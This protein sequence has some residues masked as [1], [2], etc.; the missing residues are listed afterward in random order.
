M[1]KPFAKSAMDGPPDLKGR[2]LNRAA[3]APET[4]AHFAAAGM[5]MLKIDSLR[6]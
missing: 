5:Q 4:N 6:G 2:G 3:E 1:K